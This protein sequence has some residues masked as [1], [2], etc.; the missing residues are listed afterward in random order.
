MSL[1]TGEKIG[2]KV[3]AVLPITDYV[4]QRVKTLGKPQQ[5]PFRASRILQYKWRP[6]HAVAADDE[7]LD[8]P[9]DEKNLLVP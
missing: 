2:G 4:I 7:N 9:E 5:Q 6:G 3:V 8:V 1:E